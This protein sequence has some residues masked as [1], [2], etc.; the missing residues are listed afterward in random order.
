MQD[1]IQAAHWAHAEVTIFTSLA[2]Y[3][4]KHQSNIIVSNNLNHGNNLNHSDILIQD[5]KKPIN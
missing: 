1:K 4:D 3:H 5:T 2:T